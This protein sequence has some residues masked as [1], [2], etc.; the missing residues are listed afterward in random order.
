M[1]SKIIWLTGLSGSGKTTLSNCIS[2]KLKNKKFKVKKID[3]DLFRKKNKTTKFNKSSII[4]NNLSI[5]NFV[6]KIKEKYHFII[7]SVI[8]PLKK[9]RQKAKEIFGDQ[10][11][12]VFVNCSIRGLIARDTKNL[13]KMAKIGKIKNLIGYNSKINYEKTGYKKITVHT[14]LETLKQS[15]K[16]IIDR[17]CNE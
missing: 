7:I 1:K 10:Y 12:E 17:V 15:S 3:G 14:H 4:K 8:S 2:K 11:Y 6:D 9:T 13:Y 5:I 16:K